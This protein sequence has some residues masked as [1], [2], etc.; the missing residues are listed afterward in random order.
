[1]VVVGYGWGDQYINAR[2][3]GEAQ[4]EP[5]LLVVDVSLNA[6]DR[7]LRDPFRKVA[8][9]FIGGGAK[10]ALSGGRVQVLTSDGFDKWVEGGLVEAFNAVG[11]TTMDRSY[12]KPRYGK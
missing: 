9:V 7:A 6:A 5:A 4:L 8:S 3:S 2:I 10:A 1:M 12:Y 11:L